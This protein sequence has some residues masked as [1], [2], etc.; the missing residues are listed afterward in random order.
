MQRTKDEIMVD[1]LAANGNEKELKHISTEILCDIRDAILIA[2]STFFNLNSNIGQLGNISSMLSENN[3]RTYEVKEA[4]SH[5]VTAN[6]GL[7]QIIRDGVDR[8]APPPIIVEVD[9]SGEG[10]EK[11][12]S[13][14]QLF[15]WL[16]EKLKTK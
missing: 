8:I 1:V 16:Y 10:F 13:V 3:Q 4:I 15:I 5:L 6:I 9:E 2:N 12:E 11:E 14:F 7:T